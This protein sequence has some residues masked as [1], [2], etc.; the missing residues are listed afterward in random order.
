MTEPQTPDRFKAEMPSI[1]GVA[2][3]QPARAPGNPAIRL[4]GGLLGVL[5]VVFLGARFVL[6]AKHVDP[7]V[8]Q[9]TPQIDVPA[10]A[11]DPKDAIPQSTETNPEIATLSEMSKPWSAKQF[12]FRNRLTRDSVPALLVRLP[13]GPPTQPSA[14]W[15]F[16]LNSPYGNCQLEYITDLKK[17]S[18][19]YDFRA[20]RHP[21]VGNPCSHTLFD[22]LKMANQP[23]N[24][25]VRGAI[26]QGSDVR[27]PLGIE[28]QIRGKDILAVSME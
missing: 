6:R 23:G 22:P 1:P 13:A 27:P 25:W 3:P 9:P 8:P 11:P 20:A 16:A 19:E 5:L 28:L 4:V 7:P 24:V 12:I 17:L 10:P 15:A 18:G 26:A 2:A 21:M 14:Y